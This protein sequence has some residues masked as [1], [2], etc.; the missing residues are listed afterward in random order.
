MRWSDGDD[1]EERGGEGFKWVEQR[2][3]ARLHS[4]K[5]LI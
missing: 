3:K 4:V 1:E 5:D 2:I